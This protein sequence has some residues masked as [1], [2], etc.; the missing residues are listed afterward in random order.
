MEKKGKAKA[1]GVDFYGNG[2]TSMNNRSIRNSDK[3]L[4]EGF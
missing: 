3:P 4:K 1:G 2:N